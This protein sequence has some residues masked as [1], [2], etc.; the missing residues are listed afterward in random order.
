MAC[1]GLKRLG[2]DGKIAELL[3][4]ESLIPPAGQGALAVETRAGEEGQVSAI[5]HADFHW[6]VDCERAL[7]QVLRAGCR[8]PLGA[9]AEVTGGLLRL[10]AD[11]AGIRVEA[12]GSAPLAVAQDA[13][14]QLLKAGGAEHLARWK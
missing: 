11:L 7:F 8:T 6:A 14:D 13:A 2:L 3:P 4:L 9:H 10:R 1:A 5:D 12:S